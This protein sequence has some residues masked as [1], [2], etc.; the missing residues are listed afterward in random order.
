[1]FAENNILINVKFQ[2]ELLIP[3]PVRLQTHLI[4]KQRRLIVKKWQIS[5]VGAQRT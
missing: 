5:T 3:V 4:I 1:M 2:W